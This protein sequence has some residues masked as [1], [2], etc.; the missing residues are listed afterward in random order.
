M[1]KKWGGRRNC[2]RVAGIWALKLLAG[3]QKKRFVAKLLENE[4]PKTEAFSV[5]KS[6]GSREL[7]QRKPDGRA[8]D[9]WELE[10]KG[11]RAKLPKK[12]RKKM[13]S[14]GTHK[15]TK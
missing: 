14:F 11:E 6:A 3:C 12:T 9:K 10:E 4:S 7:Q 5:Y 1:K 8:F 13:E 15:R 2:P